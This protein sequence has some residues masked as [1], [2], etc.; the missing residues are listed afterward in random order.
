M[1]GWEVNIKA[2]LKR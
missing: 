2:D 1:C